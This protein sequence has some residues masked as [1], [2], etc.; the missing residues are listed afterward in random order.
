MSLGRAEF[1]ESIFRLKVRRLMSNSKGRGEERRKESDG[2]SGGEGHGFS[3]INRP[4]VR[5]GVRSGRLSQ[6]RL[7]MMCHV[8]AIM[9]RWGMMGTGAMMER[10]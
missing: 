1:R 4:G 2:R 9:R 8:G 5:Q 10:R 3:F 7:P 6:T